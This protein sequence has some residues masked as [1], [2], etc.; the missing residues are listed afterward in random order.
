MADKDLSPIEK[1]TGKTEKSSYIFTN[2]KHPETGIM[3]SV[4][5]VIAIVSIIITLVLTFH[6]KGEALMQYGT[7]LF[8]CTLFSMIGL[9]LGVSS[10]MQRDRYYFFSYMGMITNGL[11]LIFISLILYAGAYGL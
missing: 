3:S 2:K 7:V 10:K 11:A 4:L 6:R 9:G 8:L 1:R 5:G